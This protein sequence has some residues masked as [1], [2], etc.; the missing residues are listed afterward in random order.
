MFIN[1][2]VKDE[3]WSM[4]ELISGN[5]GERKSI[6][7]RIIEGTNAELILNPLYLMNLRI[8]EPTL[9][10]LH[11]LIAYDHLEGDPRSEHYSPSVEGTPYCCDS[12]KF[13]VHGESLLGVVRT[14]YSITLSSKIP[15]KPSNLKSN[16]TT[17]NKE[18]GY[19]V[20]IL[21]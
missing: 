12:Y 18:N 9:E 8:L 6:F 20:F 19:F 10:Y 3:S 4:Q 14:C 5:E 21:S 1:I 13:K 7:L 16:V 15:I 2:T 17:D 11:K